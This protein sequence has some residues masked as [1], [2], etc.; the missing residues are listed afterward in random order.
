MFF[1]G[2]FLFAFVIWSVF[3]WG[4]QGIFLCTKGGGKQKNFGFKTTQFSC[5]E[6]GNT[7][8]LWLS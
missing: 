1:V 7:L 8:E 6:Y 5:L 2:S 3:C 4:P